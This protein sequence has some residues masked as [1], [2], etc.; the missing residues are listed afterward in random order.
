MAD[1]PSLIGQ[2]FSH[3]LI[4]EKLGGGGMGVVYK[5]EDKRL[6]RFVALK[7]LPDDVASDPQS[8]ARFRREA[9]AA[10]ALNHPNICTIHDIGEEAA[11]AFI[12]MEYLEGSTLKHIIKGKPAELEKLQDIFIE[13]ADALDAAHS[14]GIVHRDIKPANIFVT[15]RGHA[16]ILDFGLAKV[17]FEQGACFEG[18][19]TTVADEP[20]HLTSP[21]TTVGTLFYMSP[22]QIRAK[23]LDARTDLFSFGVVLYEAVTGVMP[24]RGDSSGMIFDAILNRIPTPPVRLNPDVPPELERIITRALEKDRTLRYQHAAEIRVELLRLKRDTEAPRGVGSVDDELSEGLA[25]SR[26]SEKPFGGG[27]KAVSSPNQSAA[28]GQPRILP[29]ILIAAAALILALVATGLYLRSHTSAKL[30][31]RDTIVLAD[32]TNTTGD[33]VFEGTLREGLSVQLEQ[34]P[35]LSIVSEERIQQT[36]RMMDQSPDAR[37]TP[38]IAR[39]ICQRTGSAAVLEGSVAQVGTPYLVTLKAVNCAV[40]QTLVSTEAQAS[41]KDHV[42]NALGKV[43]L[44]IRN[45]LGESLGTVAKFSAPVEQATTVSLPALQAYSQGHKY[46]DRADNMGAVPFL[47]RAVSLDPSFAMAHASLGTVHSNLSERILAREDME[48]AYGLRNRVS[49]REKFYIDSHYHDLATGNLVKARETYELWEQTYPRDQVPPNNLAIIYANLGQYD[50][51]ISA[52][53]VAKQLDPSGFSYGVLVGSYIL[54]NRLVEAQSVADEAIKKSF[55]FS[56][57]QIHLYFLAFLQNNATGMAQQVA[58]GAGKL[59]VEDN[60]LADEADTAAYSGHLGKARDF[61]RRAVFSAEHA[62]QKEAAG[63]YEAVAALREALFGNAI[64]ARQHVASALRLSSGRDTQFAAAMSLVRAG[65]IGTAQ[66]I[67]KYLAEHFPEDTIVQSNNLPVISAQLALV[68]QNTSV[69]IA[70]L[71]P[72]ALYELGTLNSYVTV[73]GLSL[74]AVYVRGEAYLA[75]RRGSE[76]SAEFQKILDHRSIVLNEPIGALAHLGLARAY[77][78]QGEPAKA[79]TAYQDFLTLWKDADADIPILIAAKAEYA[80]LQ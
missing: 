72:T 38:K 52:G 25:T 33:P 65:Q 17:V 60:L 40:G 31:E 15:E 26:R 16:K 30:T 23:D 49:E 79:R 44:D 74:Y 6:H 34:S 37:L 28:A 53:T 9:Q 71:E 12:A 35:F 42:L 48:K 59:G 70:T 8:L 54:A 75:A 41:D 4:I 46:M 63:Y 58:Y 10:S 61:S 64:E 20:L 56:D 29:R 7:F 51:S 57:L 13:I 66:K 43:S 69:A 19:R 47:Q 55:D 2:T 1:I 36:L 45:K 62:D 80:K 27:R 21:G 22:E 3:Y 5:A 73:S 77:A 11:K 67:E 76:A 39:E 14:K 68:R 50:K 18:A 78:L 32:F 24:F